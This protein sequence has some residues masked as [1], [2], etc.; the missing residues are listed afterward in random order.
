MR[1]FNIFRG[2]KGWLSMYESVIR[3]RHMRNEAE[4]RRRAKILGFWEEYGEKATKDAFG[5]SRRTLFRWREALNSSQG[6][7][8][9][10]DPKSTAPER[11]RRRVYDPAYLEK[12]MALRRSHHRLGKRKIAV[13]L[14]V[15]ESYAGR[16]LFDLKRRGLLPKHRKMTLYAHSGRVLER[17]RRTRKKLRRPQGE[18]VVQVDTIVRFVNGIKRYVVT[19]V[20]TETRFAFAAA[21][22]NHSSASAA[23][24]LAKYLTLVPIPALQTD[25][26]SEFEGYFED[27]CTRLGITRYHTYP[28]CPKMNAHV[29]RFNRTLSESFI[30]QHLTLLR[31]DI[32]VFNQKLVDELIWYNTERPHESLSLKSPLQFIIGQ[33]SARE[34]QRYWTRTFP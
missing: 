7:L 1:Q 33:L 6:K 9:A 4:V 26:G 8:P 23:D 31:D 16:T 14:A 32:D 3:F 21:Y 17:K 30:A 34:C 24:F 12:V 18:R 22:K 15:S 27:A 20:D 29:E 10:L 2:T 28:R 25:N 11:R 13:L 5:V 19:A